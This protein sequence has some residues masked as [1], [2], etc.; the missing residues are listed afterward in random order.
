MVETLG[1]LFWLT[2]ESGGFYICMVAGSALR[3]A[4]LFP[5]HDGIGS[6]LLRCNLRKSENDEFALQLLH[7]RTDC[8]HGSR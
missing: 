6:L 7:R 8:V 5:H 3:P 4:I 2:R 1:E